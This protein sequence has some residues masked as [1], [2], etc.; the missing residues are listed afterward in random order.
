MKNMN[1]KN[2]MEKDRYHKHRLKFFFFS[3][4]KIRVLRNRLA[5]YR[6][7]AKWFGILV[8]FGFEDYE[9]RYEYD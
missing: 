1:L 9:N 6:I 5:G 2:K 3:F 4:S 7:F 8:I